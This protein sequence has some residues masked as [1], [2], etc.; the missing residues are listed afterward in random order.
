MLG[1]VG[2]TSILSADT[3]PDMAL[4]PD[5]LWRGFVVYPTSIEIV[6]LVMQ[7]APPPKT[8]PR[9]HRTVP[10]PPAASSP[11]TVVARLRTRALDRF[12]LA[13]MSLSRALRPRSIVDNDV[14]NMYLKIGAMLFSHPRVS[15]VLDVGAGRAWCFPAHYKRWYGLHLVGI[16]IEAEEMADNDALDEKIVADAVEAIP[17]AADSIDLIMARSGM[18]HFADNEGFLGNAF[19]ALRPGGFLAAVFPDRFAPFAVINRML[20]P[21]LSRKVVRAT[22][23]DTA[24]ELGFRAYYDRTGYAAFGRIVERVGFTPVYHLPGFFSSTYFEFFVPA[25]MVSYL[26]DSVRAA[27]GWPRLA[28]YHLWVLQKP[29]EPDGEGALRFYAWR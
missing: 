2:R 25:W 29:G 27:I 22:M 23:L 13:N 18:E 8:L 6:P 15:H 7:A 14:F 16:D 21:R 24:G 3:T 19:A 1:I 9:P 10:G 12:V 26:Y 11:R 20:P 17:V 5:R 28:S 4:S